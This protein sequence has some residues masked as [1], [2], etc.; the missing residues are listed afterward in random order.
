M[1]SITELEGLKR[2]E[3]ARQEAMPYGLMPMDNSMQRDWGWMVEEAMFSSSYLFQIMKSYL[4]WSIN[5]SILA[6]FLPFGTLQIIHGNIIWNLTSVNQ[7][8]W[9]YLDSRSGL[10]TTTIVVCDGGDDDDGLWQWSWRGHVC[11]QRCFGSALPVIARAMCHDWPHRSERQ[12]CP[13]CLAAC[14]HH[15]DKMA[16]G[17]EGMLILGA[18]SRWK[19]GGQ[20]GFGRAGNHCEVWRDRSP[21]PP[22]I[23]YCTTGWL[24]PDTPT[25]III[26]II[27]YNVISFIL[28]LTN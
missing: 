17:E 26:I 20:G 9:L 12:R 16:S 4:L 14:T 2:K 8:C 24:H 7:S 25:I 22:S 13:Q 27:L 10:W 18:E 6:C 3:D 21:S 11:T 19:R 5:P 23:S 1:Q 15:T 28:F